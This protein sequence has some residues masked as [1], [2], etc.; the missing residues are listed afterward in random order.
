MN[1][2]RLY[3]LNAAGHFKSGDI[4]EAPSDR[5]AVAAALRELGA[6]RGELWIGGRKLALSF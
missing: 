1:Q 2:Y 6:E 4:I 5:S 3:R